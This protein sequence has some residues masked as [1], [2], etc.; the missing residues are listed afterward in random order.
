MLFWAASIAYGQVYVGV[1]FPFDVL[2]G[3]ILGALIGFLWAKLFNV[4]ILLSS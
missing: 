3:G 1:H 2:C 4:K